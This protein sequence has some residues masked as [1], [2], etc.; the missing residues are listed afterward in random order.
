MHTHLLFYK[1]YPRWWVLHSLALV[2]AILLVLFGEELPMIEIVKHPSFTLAMVGSYII[3]IVLIAYTHK[4]SVVL[5]R[6]WLFYLREHILRAARVLLQAGLVFLPSVWIAGQ[7][8]K[9]YFTWGYGMDIDDTSYP[10]YEKQ[11]IAALLLFLNLL[12]LGLSLWKREHQPRYAQVLDSKLN[13]EPL[14]LEEGVVV[15]FEEKEPRKKQWFIDLWR[16]PR[17]PMETPISGVALY[18]IAYF[19]LDSG[20]YYFYTFEGE[21]LAFNGSLNGLMEHLPTTEFFHAGRTL[22]LH[23][24]AFADKK[25]LGGSRWSVELIPPYKEPINLSRVKTRQ[26]KKW[27]KPPKK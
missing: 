26:L 5:D 12:Y 24:N 4:L 17:W 8:A 23:R 22:I 19:V 3:A 9:A 6:V 21:R 1:G 2:A 10:I 14:L 13:Q 27:L 11:Y 18:D 7:L 20:L 16:A 25:E 15:P